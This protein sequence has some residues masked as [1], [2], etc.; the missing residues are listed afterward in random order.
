MKVNLIIFILR[1]NVYSIPDIA[2]EWKDIVSANEALRRALERNTILIGG[3]PLSQ[4]AQRKHSQESHNP[5]PTLF[6][7]QSSWDKSLH[8]IRLR[9]KQREKRA[10]EAEKKADL[11]LLQQMR[12]GV[13]D[14]HV[15][16]RK[17]AIYNEHSEL[18]EAKPDQTLALQDTNSLYIHN[19]ELK[20]KDLAD[21]LMA[22]RRSHNNS[23]GWVTRE[24]K[25]AAAVRAL[26]A[27]YPVNRQS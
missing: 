4:V 6:A 14:P 3:I 8:E 2:F 15:D 24:Q 7:P 27:L 18:E 21:S 20:P 13:P 11:E 17:D 1:A 9:R 19:Q 5:L 16:I 23:Q 22:P 25:E 12:E 10:R 26:K